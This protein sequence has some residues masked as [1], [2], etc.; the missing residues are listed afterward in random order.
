M[1]QD[2]LKDKIQTL[3]MTP[4]INN[5]PAVASSATI[6][7]T[8]PGGNVI[9]S[10]VA[11]TA[12]DSTTGEISYNFLAALNNALGEN[13]QAQWTYV[14]S[15]VTYYHTSLF[16]VV[17][18]KLSIS[19]IDDDLLDEQSDIL[20]RNESQSGVV[21]SAT[22]TT[23]VDSELKKYTDSFW[24][25]GLVTVIN[26]ATGTEQTRTV[27]SFVQSTGTLTVPAWAA[28]P[29]AAYTYLARRGFTNKIAAAFNEMMID[30]KAR[31]YRP[32]LILES[33]ELRIPLIKK[34]LA[35]ICRDYIMNVG[36]KW[37]GLAKDYDA[38]YQNIF[39]KVVFQY[40]K[41]ESGYIGKDFEQDQDLGSI[42]MKR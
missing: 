26:P 14:V 34:S 25:G 12:I 30:V 37:D 16:D 13:F 40:D 24:N 15:A 19:V 28:T 42:R 20:E 3:Y 31:G 1:K 27:S 29:D 23:L 5:R 6:Q 7:I 39:G 18:N 22:S 33:S 2:I 4:Y 38:Q 8:G 10:T 21:D 9:V 41:N 17:L 35:I 36:D 11:A 32:A